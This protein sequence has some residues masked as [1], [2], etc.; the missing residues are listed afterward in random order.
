ML[1]NKSVNFVVLLVALFFSQGLAQVQ[2]DPAKW[3]EEQ[4]V[5]SLNFCEFGKTASA[6]DKQSAEASEISLSHS[7]PVPT[8]I[9]RDNFS[10]M[11]FP[12]TTQWNASAGAPLVPVK[13]FKILLPYGR[14]I[15]RIKVAPGK[16]EFIPGQFLLEP[17]GKPQPI[18]QKDG[19]DLDQA[20]YGSDQLYPGI[21]C[22]EAFFQKKRGYLI[23][24]F[25]FFPLEY[26]PFSGR[27][28]FYDQVKIVLETAP[29]PATS[30]TKPKTDA[31]T[32]SE[33][34]SLVDNPQVVESYLSVR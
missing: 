33:L 26:Y 31:E 23:L 8:I 9:Q 2:P 10:R 12:E 14:Q 11:E 21:P 20:I 30:I 22:G 5:F 18:N 32:L 34:R 29:A 25:N 24:F 3:V 15:T 4:G 13:T 19:P 17:A 16:L 28:G 27:V 6:P 7:F 1:K